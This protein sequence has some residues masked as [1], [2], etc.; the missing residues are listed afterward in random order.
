MLK[1]I[2]VYSPARIVPAIIALINLAV[3]TRVLSVEQYGYF[4][5]ATA[6]ALTLD[7]FLGQWL[8]SGIMRFHAA[9]KTKADL[10]RLLASCGVL[11][12]IPALIVCLITAT[13]FFAFWKAGTEQTL[14]LLALPYFFIHSFEQLV[15]RVHM[16]GLNSPRFVILH[17]VQSVF[18]A[19]VAA[20]LA[21]HV[22]A[23]P[24]TVLL[25]MT[26][27]FLLILLIDFRTTLRFLAL[28]RASWESVTDL[29]KFAWPTIIASGL[30]LLTSRINRFLVL[31]L[32]GP[33]AVG[34]LNATQIIAQQALASVFMLVAMAA[35]PLTVK[36][37]EQEPID[38]LRNRLSDN[39]IWIFGLGLPSAIGLIAIS[40]ELV[41]LLLD[42]TYH[43]Q[44]INIVPYLTIAAF[45]NSLR[46][47]FIIHSFFLAKKN[48]YN[49][50]VAI[51]SFILIS[52]LNYIFIPI[53]GIFGA[54]LATL[55]TEFV[56]VLLALNLTRWA[57]RLPIPYI[58]IGRIIIA[59]LVM[60]LA[61]TV[62]PSGLIL[63]TLFAKLAVG[64]MAYSIAIIITNTN[65]MRDLLL[66]YIKKM[67]RRHYIK[68]VQ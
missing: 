60:Y 58:D 2:L 48:H 45:L 34:I 1:H 39:A 59:T 17:L 35:H 4:A 53:F 43:N 14:I 47:H 32:M 6:A 10:D 9:Q 27:G 29:I 16:A 36:V 15:L 40:P 8:M 67:H 56:A 11:F 54:V 49:I 64:L 50:Y 22:S 18:S 25:G 20:A 44:A 24:A 30:S 21:I 23:D 41:T 68:S 51:P 65:E 61:I 3:F 13:I 26:S 46:S 38:A 52:L 31:A 63:T 66:K 28:W 33:A 7:G 62:I 57:I 12:L 42:S 19:A 5:L 37:Q 55:L